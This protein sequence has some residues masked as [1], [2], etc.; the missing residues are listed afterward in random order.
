MK[1]LFLLLALVMGS[2]AC[3]EKPTPLPIPTPEPEP[4]PTPVEEAVRVPFQSAIT[5]V[6]PMTTTT[7]ARK[8]MS[9]TGRPWIN[10]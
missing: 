2:C 10:C 6:Q 9:M 8:R 1:R 4:D 5:H 3:E 7:C